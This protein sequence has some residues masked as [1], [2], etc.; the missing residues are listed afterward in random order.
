MKAEKRKRSRRFAPSLIL[1]SWLVC[2]QVACVEQSAVPQPDGSSVAENQ[3]PERAEL[4]GMEYGSRAA[5]FA[6]LPPEAQAALWQAKLDDVLTAYAESGGVEILH[7]IRSLV[8]S[9]L[10]TEDGAELMIEIENLVDDAAEYFAADE[11]ACI[12]ATLE[13]VDE[14]LSAPPPNQRSP[15]QVSI[16]TCSTV[17]DYCWWWVAGVCRVTDCI[18]LPKGCGTLL[19][20][21]CNGDCVTVPAE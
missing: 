9:E 13:N 14:C 8:S 21:G 11:L 1:I 6:D 7:D 20:Y 17:S 16:C 2:Q 10:Y 15:Q 18:S 12:V 5:A 19:L 4:L 3:H